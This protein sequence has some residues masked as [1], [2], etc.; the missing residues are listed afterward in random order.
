MQIQRLVPALRGSSC[1]KAISPRDRFPSWNLNEGALKG[2]THLR[3]HQAAAPDIQ[4]L[5]ILTEA[6]VVVHGVIPTLSVY[7]PQDRVLAF[8]ARDTIDL[9]T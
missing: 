6:L 3:S 7:R 5:T 9:Y 1:T 2:W 8:A 4:M